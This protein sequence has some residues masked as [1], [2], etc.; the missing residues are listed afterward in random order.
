MPGL[1][2][3]EISRGIAAT[4][5][6]SVTEAHR[7]IGRHV[8]AALFLLAIAI[9]VRERAL[10]EIA[11]PGDPVTVRLPV[12]IG[13]R[14][15]HDFEA[16]AMTTGLRV[17]ENLLL[18]DLKGLTGAAVHAVGREGRPHRGDATDG[19]SL[20]YRRTSSAHR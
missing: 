16:N 12:T 2:V 11:T 4:S 15:A 10:R 19:V 18:A 7:G 3:V 5:V 17:E 6:L 20:S 8:T 13:A 1:R 14:I 9:R